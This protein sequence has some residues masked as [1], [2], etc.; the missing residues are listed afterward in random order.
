[1]REIRTSGST[2]GR[3]RRNKGGRMG[4]GYQKG[5]SLETT[6]VLAPRHLST[7]LLTTRKAP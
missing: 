4:L 3:W 1:M 7:L 2:S 6:W 5:P